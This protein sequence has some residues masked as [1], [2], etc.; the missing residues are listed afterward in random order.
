MGKRFFTQ[1]LVDKIRK[2]FRNSKYRWFAIIAGLVYLVSPLDIS[3]DVVPILGWLD[4]GLIASLVI[5]EVS[6]IVAEKLKNRQK[7][8]SATANPTQTPAVIDVNAV[9]LN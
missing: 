7:G 2:I 5:A 6:Q 3:P 8:N 1:L 9:S 4:D